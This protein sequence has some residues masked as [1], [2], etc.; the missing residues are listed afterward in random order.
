MA[1]KE[2]R[3]FIPNEV[4]CHTHPRAHQG[5]SGSSGFKNCLTK[6][7]VTRGIRKDSRL[8]VCSPKFLPS[9]RPDKGTS[10]RDVQ[11]SSE[12]DQT[13]NVSGNARIATSFVASD[14]RARPFAITQIRE[15]KQQILHIPVLCQPS[16]EHDLSPVATNVG[17][18]I[19]VYVDSHRN[20]AN[21]RHV[22]S[23]A[24]RLLR[25]RLRR[26]DKAISG[27]RWQHRGER[28]V[29]VVERAAPAPNNLPEA[30]QC[31]VKLENER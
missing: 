28:I 22:K 9:K 14:N 23:I 11:L 25:L 20:D 30:A 17:K 1:D 24:S 16:D 19:S 4:G 26:N 18:N 10:V 21:A 29:S 8:T 2:A 13:G 5:A 6:I 15:S 27:E 31:A 7:F 12:R 3:P